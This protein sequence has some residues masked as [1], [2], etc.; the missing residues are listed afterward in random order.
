MTDS[1]RP[2]S[3][4]SRRA[5]LGGALSALA[6]PA[7]AQAPARSLRPMLRPAT[8]GMKLAPSGASLVDKANLTG[9]VGYMVADA[10]SRMSLEGRDTRVKLPPASVAKALTALYALEVLGPDHRFETRLIATGPVEKG[11]LQGDLVLAG[12]GDP[13]LDT[14]GLG[15]L[16]ANLKEAGVTEVAGD[17]LVY[18][19]T[20]PFVP[21]IDVEQP[22]HVGYS[23]AV[24]GLNLNFNRVH[25]EW[26]RQGG[27]YTVTMDAR[28]GKYRP[29]VTVARM[30]VADRAG[31]VYTYEDRGGRDEWTVADSALGTGG[32]RWLPVRKPE[33]YA[34]EV[35]E[36]LARAHGIVLK[37]AKLA[38][39]PPAG[40]VLVRHQSG[41][42]VGIL[43]DMLYHSTNITAECV[44]MAASRKRVPG[45]ASL[46]ES[47]AAM[48]DWLKARFRVDG[49][50]LVDH[51]GL[52]GDSRV[53]AGSM[54][55]VLSD[56]ESQA[57][58]T[59]IL[60]KITMR[61]SQRRPLPNSRTRVVAKTGTLNFVSGLA[62][63]IT[64]PGGR[65]LVFAIFCSDV[66]RRE[67][68]GEHERERPPGMM[69]WNGR[70]KI[71]QQDL[72]DRWSEVY[73]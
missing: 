61:D 25:F 10:D 41:P 49:M 19:G 45:T 47:A 24:S 43:E 26:K 16:A 18:G 37:G 31:P 27:K 70:A 72:I 62:G 46:V 29:D 63:Y 11:R 7:L 57:R 35:F 17:F 22:D 20:L 21:T 23:P 30:S 53:M 51:S 40:E 1:T 8:L 2:R 65:N 6:V 58:L 34:G 48:S 13:T 52:G 55:R 69:A 5:L 38:E 36:T 54:V 59:P 44:G 60:K 73:G 66:P 3:T 33:L 14:D 56:P 50:A 32:A 68:L 15:R 67:A 12:T 28:T 42:L 4:L 9:R 71:L 64:T 39:L